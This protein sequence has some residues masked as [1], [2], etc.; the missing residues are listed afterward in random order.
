MINSIDFNKKAREPDPERMIKP[1]TK[2]LNSK[3]IKSIYGGYAD[4]S[5]IQ[6]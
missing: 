2:Q 5:T 6:S 3:F 1:T 4:L